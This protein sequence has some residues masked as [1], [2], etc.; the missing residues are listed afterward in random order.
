MAKVGS[1]A[2]AEAGDFYI[3][4]TPYDLKP[5]LMIIVIVIVVSGVIYVI[6]KWRKKPRLVKYMY[7]EECKRRFKKGK[8][9]LG[10]GKK[11]I[12][13]EVWKK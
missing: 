13:K 9:C 6:Y 1:G 8:F 10:C 12:Q 5:P 2:F 7:C 3:K 4:Y 11:L